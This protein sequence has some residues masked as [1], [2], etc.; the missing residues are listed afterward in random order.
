MYLTVYV[1][2]TYWILFL[3]ASI[4][5]R[6]FSNKFPKP[7]FLSLVVKRTTSYIIDIKNLLD[8]FKASAPQ[9]VNIMDR[10][11]SEATKHYKMWFNTI[12]NR[13]DY[14]HKWRLALRFHLFLQMYLLR[15]RLCKSWELSVFLCS[16][17][18]FCLLVRNR[19]AILPGSQ[20]KKKLREIRTKWYMRIKNQMK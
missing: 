2:F 15:Q 8:L 18:F 5:M 1:V 4:K 19:F 9:H 12:C 3:C 10:M 6:S 11:L 14:K 17:L 20:G 7:H 13:S 16:Y